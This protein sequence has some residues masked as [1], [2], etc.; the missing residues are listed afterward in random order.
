MSGAAVA[1][2]RALQNTRCETHHPPDPVHE[3]FTMAA[4]APMTME[5]SIDDSDLS[6]NFKL[7][8][9]GSNKVLYYAPFHKNFGKTCGV[10]PSST[11]VRLLPRSRTQRAMVSSLLESRGIVRSIHSAAIRARRRVRARIQAIPILHTERFVGRAGARQ[12]ASREIVEP[13][14][15][16]QVS[17]SP[18]ARSKSGMPSR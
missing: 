3:Y 7:N 4:P 12:S 15:R 17:T 2:P 8:G 5:P 13:L 10:I 16:A 6:G 9:A 11:W 18:P 1:A 14:P